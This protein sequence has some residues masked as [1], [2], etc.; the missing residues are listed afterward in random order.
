MRT[1]AMVLAMTVVAAAC[2]GDGGGADDDVG[3]GVSTTTPSSAP[4]TTA[5]ATGPRTDLTLRIT[6]LRLENSEESDNG[7]R[8]LLPDGVTTASVTLAGLP[9]P[10]R[11]I[12]VCQARELDR[13]LST[14]VCRQPA[15]GEAVT[16]A[17]GAEASGVEIVQA[18]LS[19]S[20]PE[21]NATTLGD[22][23][24]RY[25]ASSREVDVRLSQIPA[26]EAG[27]RPSFSLTPAGTTGAYRAALTW[28]VIQVFG[29]TPS[30]A[31]LELVRGGNVVDS[32]QSGGLQV[33]LNGT[34]TP[35]GGDAAVRVQNVGPSAL[36]GPKLDML[37]P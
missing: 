19:S 23:T 4:S 30:N 8:I 28:T 35:P 29:G 1:I 21:G 5:A 33:Q 37:L 15:S 25:A 26:G 12:S 18:G 20:G 32:A 11:V 31:Q 34:M 16:V 9:S 24:I 13:R 22:V 14:A 36:V 27:A 3:A 7:V 6:D 2:G 17:L 10:N